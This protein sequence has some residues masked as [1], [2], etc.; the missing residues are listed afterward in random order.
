MDS[1]RAE[2]GDPERTTYDDEQDVDTEY[3]IVEY[4]WF[5]PVTADSVA[6]VNFRWASDQDFCEIFEG[7]PEG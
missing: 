5:Y 1:V 7:S 2:R 4:H 6:V 3:Q